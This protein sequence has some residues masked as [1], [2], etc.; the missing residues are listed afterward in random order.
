MFYVRARGVHKILRITH[1]LPPV[2]VR[3]FIALK[4]QVRCHLSNL[5]KEDRWPGAR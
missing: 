3:I 4:D 1:Y 2:P 5:M